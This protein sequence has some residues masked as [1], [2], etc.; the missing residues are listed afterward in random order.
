MTQWEKFWNDEAQLEV[1]RPIDLAKISDFLQYSSGSTET[2]HFNNVKIDSLYYTK[3]SHDRNKMKAE[4]CFYHLA[5][6]RM[7]PWFVETFDFKEDNDQS[8]FTMPLQKKP[9][10]LLFNG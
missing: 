7:K 2:R 3:S 1:N 8:G 9:F 10:C 4:Y 5:S 6:E